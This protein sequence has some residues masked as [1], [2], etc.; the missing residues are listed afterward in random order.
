VSAGTAFA[1]G[2]ALLAGI[3]GSVQIGVMGTFGERIGV[4]AALAFSLLL[5]TVVA[6]AA[7]ATTARSLG[8][9]ADAVRAPAWL[10]I[11]GLMGVFIVFTITFSTPRIGATATIGILI[12]GQL[13]MGVAIDRWGLFGLEQIALTPPRVLGIVLLAAGAALS[14][15]KG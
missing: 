3:A 4:L 5:S 1:A 8:G 2:L 15:H 12:A 6:T 14:L 11:G 7:L 10:W 9:F 13:A